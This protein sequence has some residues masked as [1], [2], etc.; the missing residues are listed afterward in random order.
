MSGLT[1]KERETIE[2]AVYILE[3]ICR[4]LDLAKDSAGSYHSIDS[5]YEK[6]MLEGT[7]GLVWEGNDGWTYEQPSLAKAKAIIAYHNE[8]SDYGWGIEPTE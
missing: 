6:M 2:H 7:E 5:E 4:E 3:C 1:D 8:F